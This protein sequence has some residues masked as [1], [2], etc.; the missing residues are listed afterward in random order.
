MRKGPYVYPKG[1]YPHIVAASGREETLMWAYDR[2]DGGRG[3]GF[4]LEARNQRAVAVGDVA[5]AG[6]GALAG[7]LARDAHAGAR[8]GCGERASEREGG[9][10]SWVFPRP[11]YQDELDWMA[12]AREGGE[13]GQ[14]A[15][16]LREL[17]RLY[18]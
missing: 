5:D 12:A 11:W 14:G 8:H 17:L 9:A 6:A 7:H 13:Q 3:F 18:A 15:G 2:P 16:A 4:G 10:V 1:P